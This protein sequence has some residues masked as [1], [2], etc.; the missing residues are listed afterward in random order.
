[1]SDE[2]L[3]R[4]ERAAASGDLAA[5]GRLLLARVR[6][7]QLTTAQL[8]LRAYLGS[9]AAHLALGNDT[10]P[11]KLPEP[12]GWVLGL[13]SFGQE[14]WVRTFLALGE[15]LLELAPA[16]SLFR[17]HTEPQ[18]VPAHFLPLIEALRA[19]LAGS[20]RGG[21]LPQVLEQ[22]ERM[23]GLTHSFGHAGE[24]SDALRIASQACRPEWSVATPEATVLRGVSEAL[25][26][27]TRE[28]LEGVGATVRLELAGERMTVLLLD[29][30]PRKIA[31]IAA[32]RRATDLGLQKTMTLIEGV[33]AVGGPVRGYLRE[34]EVAELRALLRAALVSE[35]WETP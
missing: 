14:V 17:Q 28:E 25:A 1:M 33:D 24:V 20:D 32:V 4:A 19:W 30:G 18:P 12:T 10:A 5:E 23:I 15:G 26:L 3:R 9:R 11:A 8:E 31:V 22:T 21:A 34:G 6:A 2:A 16:L 35:P 7:G 27:R 13:R 29:R